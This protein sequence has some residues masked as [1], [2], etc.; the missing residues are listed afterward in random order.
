MSVGASMRESMT[1]IHTDDQG[2]SD[3]AIT[4]TCAY[5]RE[6]RQWVGVCEELGTSAFSD[7][8]EQAQAELREAIELQLNEI[9]RLGYT[10]EYLEKNQVR[11]VPIS[12]NRQT[13]FTFATAGRLERIGA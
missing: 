8:L 1:I 5:K 3:Y 2:F 12:V 9:E 11:V 10:Q 7:T 13:G 4:L 6:S